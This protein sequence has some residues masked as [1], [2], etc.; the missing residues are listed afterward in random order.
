M[1]FEYFPVGVAKKVA[2]FEVRPKTLWKGEKTLVAS[3]V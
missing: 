3:A 1:L 2:D